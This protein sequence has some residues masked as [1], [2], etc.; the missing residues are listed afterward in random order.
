MKDEVLVSV[1][2]PMYN[3][4]KHLDACLR[5]ICN[6]SYKN[7]EVIIVNDGSKDKS[8]LIAHRWADKDARVRVI[9]KNNE[10]TSF[11]RRDGYLNSK[12]DFITF[13][14]NDD[15]LP[16]NAIELMVRHMVEKDVDL[17][18]GSVTRFFGWIRQNKPFGT[19][20]VDEIVRVPRLF[21]DYYLG[22]FRNTIFPVNMWGRLFRKSVV[23]KAYQDT[24]LFS[25]AMPCMAGDEYFNLKLFPYLSSMYRTDEPVYNYRYGGTVDHFN[26]FFPEVFVL[27]ELRVKLLDQFHY[28]EGYE[29]L[30]EEYVNMVYYHAEQYILYNQGDKDD[31]IAFFKKELESR[32]LVPRLEKFYTEIGT[33]DEGTLLLIN[34]D[35]ERMYDHAQQL[36]D[37]LR[38]QLRYRLKRTLLTVAERFF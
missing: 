15:M 26:K 21:D 30:F 31:V 2:V 1:I 27:S 33:D 9:D 6:Q 37:S 18:Y 36:A 35:Y 4:E 13:V 23:D 16:K 20:P 19:F 12:G 3:Q 17:V 25:P 29:P 38:S 10:G 7:I 11:A 24:E 22:F 8:P 28:T 34:R 14:D 32:E 5:S